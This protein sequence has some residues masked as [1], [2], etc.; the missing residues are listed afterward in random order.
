MSIRFKMWMEIFNSIACYAR[1]PAV[2]GWKKLDLKPSLKSLISSHEKTRL[3][4][5]AL[6]KCPDLT[7]ENLEPETIEAIEAAKKVLNNT[8]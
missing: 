1:T 3:A 2:G 4:L 8:N 6:L 5:L 7:L